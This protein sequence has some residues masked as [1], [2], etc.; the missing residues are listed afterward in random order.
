MS[1]VPDHPVPHAPLR[2]LTVLLVSLLILIPCFW[3]AHIQAGDLGSH[4]YNAWLALLIARGEAPGLYLAVQWKNVL[5]DLLLFYLCKLFGFALGEKFAVSICVLIFFWGVFAFLRVTTG[6]SPWFLTPVLAMLSYGYVFHMG[7]MNYYLSIGL[8]L[9]A[10]ARVWNAN[11]RG[12]IVGMLLLPLL[13]LAHPLGFL[14]FLSIAG[15]WFVR[16]RLSGWWRL[17][18][19]ALA[20]ASL[21]V[22]HIYFV[23]NEKVLSAAWPVRP[24]LQ[25]NGTD[26]FSLFGP[27]YNHLA[28]AMVGFGLLGAAIAVFTEENGSSVWKT[29]ILF[30]ELYVISFAAMLLLP[31]DLRPYPQG[32]WIGEIV[33][34]LTVIATIFAIGVLATL[35]PRLWQ[36]AGFVLIALVY[37]T[38]VYRDTGVLD[39]MERNA[40]ALTRALPYGTRVASTVYSPPGYRPFYEHLVDRACTGVCYHYSNYEPSTH[41]FRVRVVP[42]GSPLVAGTV[43]ESEDLQFGNYDIEE[44]DLPMKQIYQCDPSDLT[45][46]CIRDLQPGENNGRLGYRPA[47]FPW[48]P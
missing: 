18:L 46:L 41:E 38:F 34:R 42:D 1:L 4:V 47:H 12:L 21:I 22:L 2:T 31:Q 25:W 37:F 5:F 28:L 45:K 11:V 35:P 17:A 16:A 8:A 29:R 32:S 15:Y 36:L 24:I 27:V 13:Y 19:P 9:L 40:E 26:Q 6:R 23:R 14:F 39:R 7:F 30:V 33:T 44:S 3:H 43:V 20:I 48:D 10:L